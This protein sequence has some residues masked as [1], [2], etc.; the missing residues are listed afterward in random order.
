MPPLTLFNEHSTYFA[1][2]ES[3][4]PASAASLN[5]QGVVLVDLSDKPRALLVLTRAGLQ[6]VAD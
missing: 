1:I 6:A 2:L 4:P 5:N 3:I